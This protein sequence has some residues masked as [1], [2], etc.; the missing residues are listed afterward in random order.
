MGHLL[1]AKYPTALE[2][3]SDLIMQRRRGLIDN[4]PFTIQAIRTSGLTGAKVHN[5]YI[6][7][8]AAADLQDIITWDRRHPDKTIDLDTISDFVGIDYPGSGKYFEERRWQDIPGLHA[9]FMFS[10]GI[11]GDADVKALVARHGY[12]K[13]ILP[14]H[15]ISDFDAEVKYIEEFNLRMWL[16]QEVLAARADYID[17]NL[18]AAKLTEFATKAHM[19][20]EEITALIASADLRKEI[21]TTTKPKGSKPFSITQLID[22]Q[23]ETVIDQPFV[24]ADITAYGY[25]P[26]HT[27]A[28]TDYI[29]KK[30]AEKQAKSAA[31]AAKKTQPAS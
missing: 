3:L 23:F 19:Q 7:S 29:A 27:K 26:A 20:P 17:G 10:L 14:G 4:D 2:S 1:N 21:S 9:R 31:A 15:S 25:D 13:D 16:R 12:R 18:D 22:Y 24:D 11:Y 6:Q 30:V 5:A 28:I 8:L